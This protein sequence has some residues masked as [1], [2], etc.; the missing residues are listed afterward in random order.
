MNSTKKANK[1]FP[2]VFSRD[3]LEW[4]TSREVAERF[5]KNHKDVLRAIENSRKECPVGWGQRNF[6]LSSYQNAQN[7]EQPLVE[8]TRS[9]FAIVVM[10]FTGAEA[11]EWKVRFL[12][13]FDFLV[14]ALPGESQTQTTNCR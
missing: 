2:Q 6:A 10:G 11:M 14:D 3:D 5:G 4:T 9:G 8:M 13:A 7:K 12:D 1:N